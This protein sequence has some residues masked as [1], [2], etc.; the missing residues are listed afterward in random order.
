MSPQKIKLTVTSEDL[1]TIA[2]AA[3]EL[4]VH[5]ATVYRWVEKRKIHPLHIGEQLFVT[6]DEVRTVK[7]QR[8]G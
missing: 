2:Q 1:L 7:E 4:G 8:G 3:E 6:V 5:L